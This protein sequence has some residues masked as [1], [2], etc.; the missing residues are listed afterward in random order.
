VWWN[1]EVFVRSG[2]TGIGG[3][4]GSGSGKGS[5]YSMSS[6][7]GVRSDPTITDSDVCQ[8]YLTQ[9]SHAIENIKTS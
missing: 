6:S 8:G 3:G 7:D 5:P 2:P 1:I 4:S 9:P